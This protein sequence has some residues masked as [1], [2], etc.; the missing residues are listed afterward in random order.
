M[1]IVALLL[2][3]NLFALCLLLKPNFVVGRIYIMGSR[4][5]FNKVKV[6]FVQRSQKNE[7]DEKIEGMG[8]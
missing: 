3:S 7:V 1:R 4:I 6:F 2:A 8:P 5:I